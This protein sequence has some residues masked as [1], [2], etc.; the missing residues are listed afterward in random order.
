MYV[1]YKYA[2]YGTKIGVLSHVDNFFYCY[3][4][5]SLGGKFVDTL[6]KRFYV[7]FLVYLHWFMSIRIFQMRYNSISV[8]KARYATSI[9]AEY[10]DNATLKTGK[11]F[12]MTTLPY[13][14]IFTKD[15]AS[16]SDE[17]V[18]NLTR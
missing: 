10:M 3:K 2:P 13:D 6:G 15:D 12:Y 1:Y 17:K 8:D 18:D 11:K 5:E 16:T 9:V 7:N 4:S 14:M